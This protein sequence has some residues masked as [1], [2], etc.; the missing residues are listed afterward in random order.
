MEDGEIKAVIRGRIRIAESTLVYCLRFTFSSGHVQL[1]SWG[2]KTMD[3]DGV[4]VDFS[5]VTR[6]K[7]RAR[8]FRGYVTTAR[9]SEMATI[10]HGLFY[11]R[12]SMT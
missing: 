11:H 4:K 5:A 2:T 1:L 12:T 3:I 6:K 8:M 7:Q 9:S 10:S